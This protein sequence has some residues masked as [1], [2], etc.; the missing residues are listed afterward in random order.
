L[1]HVQRNQ[2]TVSSL[3]PIGREKYSILVIQ[4]VLELNNNAIDMIPD[5]YRANSI[6]VVIGMSET[7]S[8]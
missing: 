2:G 1:G 3:L 8:W 7:L 5:N 6:D 4:E